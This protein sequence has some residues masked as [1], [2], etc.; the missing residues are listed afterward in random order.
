MQAQE[1]L[2]VTLGPGIY[3]ARSTRDRPFEQYRLDG[4]FVICERVTCNARSSGAP[5]VKYLQSWTVSDF[6][7]AN[8]LPR[9]KASLQQILSERHAEGTLKA[10]LV[11]AYPANGLQ[12][13]TPPFQR[14]P[15]L[16]AGSHTIVAIEDELN[17]LAHVQRN[18]PARSGCPQPWT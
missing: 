17:A 16:H 8:V 18:R 3:R 9:A 6:L 5:H 14:L 1:Q 12:I 15:W 2:A 4:E 7:I 13:S 11:N 10:V